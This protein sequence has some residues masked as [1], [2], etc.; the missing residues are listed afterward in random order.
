MRA[1]AVWRLE[2]VE[3]KVNALYGQVMEG[4]PNASLHFLQRLE[5]VTAEQVMIA[6]RQHIADRHRV[7]LSVVPKGEPAGRLRVRTMF[8]PRGRS[9]RI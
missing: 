1:Q 4:D 6:Y 5:A 8:R 9:L 7:L 2:S 3:D